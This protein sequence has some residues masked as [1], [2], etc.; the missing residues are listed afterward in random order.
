MIVAIV[1]LILTLI[2][3]SIVAIV[4]YDQICVARVPFVRLLPS[5][6]Q[7]I[8]TDLHLKPGNIVYDLG[9]GDG[10]VLIEAAKTQPNSTYIGIEKAFVPYLL[11]KFRTRHC[12]Q[13]TIHRDDITKANFQNA[14]LVFMYLMPELINKIEP[15]LKYVHDQHQHIIAVEFP[16]LAHRPSKQ[17]LLK[18]PSQHATSWYYY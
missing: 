8:F 5:T 4:A 7:E 17:F 2:L 10:R 9:C 12:S 1:F 16:L 6:I 15:Q 18:H 14:T 3:T 11:A 13:I